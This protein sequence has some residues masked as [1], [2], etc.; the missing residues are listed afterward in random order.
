[1]RSFLA[2]LAMPTVLFLLLLM[3]GAGTA[4][5]Q[6]AFYVTGSQF[7]EACWQRHAKEKKEGGFKDV[8]ADNP[9]QAALWA[10]CTPLVAETMDKIGFAIGDSRP[11]ASAEARALA[12]DCPNA[13]T[14]L[15]LA[16]DRLYFLVIEAI[17]KLGGP[18]TVEG[19]A[20]A[21][22]VIERALKARWPR[23]IDAARPYIAKARN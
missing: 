12:P 4:A 14:E 5:A 2:M 22:W 19:F 13:F 10:R 6:G 21:G 11:N 18:T 8:E 9:S 20:P 16:I 7:Y 1:M 3:G 15:P 23:C 17:E